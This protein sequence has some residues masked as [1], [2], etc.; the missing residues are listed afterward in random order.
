[1]IPSPLMSVPGQRPGGPRLGAYRPQGREQDL[2]SRLGRTRRT[3]PKGGNPV[4]VK[5]RPAGPRRRA[6]RAVEPVP[7]EGAAGGDSITVTCGKAAT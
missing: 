4:G 1:M 2:R 6:E 5:P 3:A 7:Q